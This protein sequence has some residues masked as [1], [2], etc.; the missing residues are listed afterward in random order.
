M[1]DLEPEHGRDGKQEKPGVEGTQVSHQGTAST[2]AEK[3]KTLRHISGNFRGTNDKDP[4]NPFSEII[5]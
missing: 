3:E 1:R 4:M 2:K 5:I